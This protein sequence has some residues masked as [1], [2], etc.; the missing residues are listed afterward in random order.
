MNIRAVRVFI[1]ALFAMPFC[2]LAG[3]A[4]ALEPY[5]ATASIGDSATCQ[6]RQCILNFP[7]VPAQRRLVVT[8]VSAQLGDVADQIVLEN[9]GVTYFVP[10]SHPDLGYLAAPVT[11]H[12]DQGAQPTARIFAPDP[13]KHVS[14]IVTLVGHL[15]VRK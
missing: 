5:Q 6:N 1:L 15:V 13:T 3:P 12:F 7:P 9:N 14:L 8:S 10:K 11:I 4:G 2:G